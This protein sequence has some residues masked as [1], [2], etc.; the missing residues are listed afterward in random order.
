M[1]DPGVV[2][3]RSVEVGLLSQ[4]ARGRAHQ[5]PEHCQP[6]LPRP[7][8][9]VERGAQLFERLNVDFLDIGDMRDAHHRQCEGLIA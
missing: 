1:K 3:E 8:L 5:E 7:L 6:R 2:V 9:L 4:R